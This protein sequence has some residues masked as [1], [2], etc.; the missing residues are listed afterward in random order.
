M[1]ERTPQTRR[2]AALR[3]RTAAAAALAVLLAAAIAVLWR[4]GGFAAA[5]DRPP[6][7]SGSAVGNDLYTLVPERAELVEEERLGEKEYLVE[8]HARLESRE[9]S[10]QRSSLFLELMRLEAEPG[11]AR[12]E[13][14]AL[15][16]VRDGSRPAQRWVQPGTVREV[17]LVWRLPSEESTAE[18]WTAWS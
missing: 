4:Q 11:G 5:A 2:R 14:E 16:L 9:E 15:K 1:A 17:V 7:R 18:G 8:V 10:P 3:G 13:P 6:Q 12:A